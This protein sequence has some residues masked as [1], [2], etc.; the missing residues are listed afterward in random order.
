MSHINNKTLR[1][2]VDAVLI[3]VGIVFLVFGIKDAV[4]MY[5]SST[6]PDDV[7]FSRSY[8]D[9]SEDNPYEYVTSR[10]FEDL[11]KSGTGVIF[12]GNPNDAWS[13]VLAGPL[14]DVLKKYELEHVYYFETEEDTPRVLI[15]RDGGKIEEFA[16]SDIFDEEYDGIPIEYFGEEEHKNNLER[17][18]EVIEKIK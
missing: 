9:V 8:R 13:Q 10:E 15:V 7:L 4:E 6:T 1:I 3:I 11:T 2:V 5:K 12:V 17:L 18:L 14:T 16:K